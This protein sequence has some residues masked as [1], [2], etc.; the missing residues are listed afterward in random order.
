M[1]WAVNSMI[2]VVK[3]SIPFLPINPFSLMVKHY[4]SNIIYKSSSL[5]KDLIK[6]LYFLGR[7]DV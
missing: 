2:Q 1:G 5:L 7:F 6:D 4:T 3:G